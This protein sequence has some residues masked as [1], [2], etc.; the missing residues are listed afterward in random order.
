LLRGEGGLGTHQPTWVVSMF[1]TAETSLDTIAVYEHDAINFVG[2]YA[3]EC[4]P[5]AC[6]ISTRSPGTKR[7]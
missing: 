7:W 2:Q 1:P 6:D 3:R 5:D 4:E